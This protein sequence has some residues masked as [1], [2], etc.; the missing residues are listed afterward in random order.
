MDRWKKQFTLLTVLLLVL[1]VL[2]GCQMIDRL[3]ARDHL[4]KGVKA[5]SGE[6]W[7]T[8]VEEF[9]QAIELDPELTIALTYLATT[10][11]AQ[12]VPGIPG[13]ENEQKAETAIKTFERVLVT[14]PGDLNAIANIAGIY[15]NLDE[16]DKAKEWYRK[17]IEVAPENPEPYYGIGT[18]DW[19]IAHEET[20]MNGENVE[21]LEEERRAEVTRWVE[22]GVQT[23]QKALEL[24]PE[25]SE[26]MQF[27]N[28]LYRERSYLATDEE[29]KK[30]WEN[31]AFKLALQALDLKR[32]QEEEA[33]KARHSF[34]TKAQE[35]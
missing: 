28:L 5:Y 9:S 3:K 29:E 35:N 13:R 10:Y 12:F 26:A 16:H 32:K 17:Q 21:N 23:L 8:A 25:Y 18:I 14:Q 2:S 19:K 7:D 15:S 20:G 33:E 6:R 30:Q 1:S 31:E 11:R 24:N 27:L 22:D 4:N 34:G